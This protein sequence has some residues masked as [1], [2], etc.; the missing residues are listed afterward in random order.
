PAASR[1]DV[2]VI[3]EGTAFE[4]GK[5]GGFHNREI[6]LP[7]ASVFS[8]L[9]NPEPIQQ[10]H[11][12]MLHRAKAAKSAIRG[13]TR[14]L[15]AGTPKPRD[16][17]DAKVDGPALELER[18][19]DRVYIPA[20][21]SAAERRA[22]GDMDYLA[23]WSERLSELTRSTFQQAMRGIPTSGARRYEREILAASWL[24]YRLRV[25]RGEVAGGEENEN[26]TDTFKEEESE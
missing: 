1:T 4:Q 15:L 22:R 26:A 10:T 12:E 8:F 13:A 24:D 19:I 11:T 3:F 2:R 5:T 7:S 20:L 18:A 25:M 14:I 6:L 17:D 21:L 9:A 23:E 16:G